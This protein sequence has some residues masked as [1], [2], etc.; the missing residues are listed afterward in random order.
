MAESTTRRGKITPENIAESRLLKTLY[1]TVPHKLTQEAFGQKYGIGN[2][3]AVWQFL[4]GKTAI[5]MNAAKGFADGLE[6]EISAFSPRLAKKAAELGL[7]VNPKMNEFASVPQ[8]RVGFSAGHDSVVYDEGR[9]SSL[10]FRR[11]YLES[12]GVRDR[13]AVIVNVTGHGMEPTIDDGSVLLV[14]RAYQEVTNG[15]IYAFR[16]ESQLYIKRMHKRATK[17][18]A[19]SD[20]PDKATYPDME[21]GLGVSDFEM[22]G[23]AMWMGKKL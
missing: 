4:N 20:N 9:R 7:L 16:L 5:S 3:G 10:S 6:C 13:H 22:I 17:Y 15:L 23:R 19:L 8:A 11:D 18:H 21:I 12:L 1:Q 14:N 2:Q